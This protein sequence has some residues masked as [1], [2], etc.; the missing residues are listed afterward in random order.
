MSARIIDG[1]AI[2]AE[3]RARVKADV[4]EMDVKPG[5][6]TILVG[7]DPASHVYVRNKRKACE[8]V[9]IRSIHHELDASVPEEDL[10]EVKAATLED[11]K[12]FYADFYGASVGEL[13]IV[14]DIDAVEAGKLAQ[15]LFVGQLLEVGDLQLAG[16]DVLGER[17]QR[18]DL[19]VREAGGRAHG[20][21]VVGEEF[22][23]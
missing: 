3:V 4:A 19:G 15:D 5:L 20:V 8:E 9:G 17:A 1:K 22:L 23:G 14:G 13:A 6:A 10:A 16:E 2:S 21:R 11:V 18:D 7:D 12:K